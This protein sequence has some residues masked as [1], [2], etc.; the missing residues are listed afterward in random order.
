MSSIED[1]DDNVVIMTLQAETGS[2]AAAFLIEM[3][4]MY[5]LYAQKHHWV[6]QTHLTNQVMK[7]EA[8]IQFT[9]QGV[10]HRLQFEQGTHRV[11]RIPI[12]EPLGRVKTSL[13]HVLV[14]PSPSV[15]EIVGPIGD[16]QER[17]RTYNVPQNRATDHRS[18]V[19]IRPLTE[20]LAGF[21]DPFIDALSG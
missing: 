15:G 2:D 11:Q 14:R 1:Y 5:Q 9:G 21:L 13:I 6:T 12:A 17:I 20:V 8:T 4:A 3:V 16:P 19:T 7:L 10:Y 18:N